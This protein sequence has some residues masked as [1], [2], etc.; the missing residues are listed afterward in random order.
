M[1][2]RVV[3]V[4]PYHAQ[5]GAL[6]H[7]VSQR[8]LVDARKLGDEQD[9][10]ITNIFSR[11]WRDDPTVLVLAV[12]EDDTGELVGYGVVSIEGNQAFLMQ[13]RFDHPTD[14]DATGELLSIAETWV[15]DYNTAMGAELITKLTL[16]ARRF[17]PKWAKKYGFETKR[18]L[19]EKKLGE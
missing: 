17:D 16:V 14:H 12:L 6:A 19:M 2:N 1:A 9:F 3:V 8:L 15:K 7:L 18:Y 13:P 11:L 4:D 10:T 5:L